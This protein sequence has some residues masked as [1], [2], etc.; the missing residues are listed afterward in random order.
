MSKFRFEDLEIWKLGQEIGA[1][2]YAIADLL[3][4][5]GNSDLRSN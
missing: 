1:E 4:E 5:K 3:E 2:L